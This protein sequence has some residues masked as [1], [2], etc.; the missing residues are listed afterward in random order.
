MGNIVTNV[1]FQPPEPSIMDPQRFFL[2]E[3]TELSSETSQ[4]S[5]TSEKI[6]AFYIDRNSTMTILFSHGN[7]EDIGQIYN[8]FWEFSKKLNVNIMAYDYAGY[9]KSTDKKPKEK[10]CYKGIEAAYKFLI[11]CKNQKP[12]QI[13]LYGRS[14][15]SGPS[16]YLAEKLSS[17]GTPPAGLMLQ[18]PISPCYRVAIPF[19]FT[20]YGDPFPNIDR[21]KRI[22]C[23]VFI[24]HGTRDEIV[25]FK[26]GQDLFLACLEK[27]R[28]KPFWVEGA[29]HNNIENYLK[30]SGLFLTRINIFLNENCRSSVVSHKNSS[31]S[32]AVK[33]S[34]I[35]S[36]IDYN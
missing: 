17:F 27:Y 36:K 9:G 26:H 24:I 19:R 10:K 33:T 5:H 3:T 32:S 25:P 13:I 15:G 4:Q 28:V 14:I 8:W 22:S 7:A 30:D 34:S 23:P 12:N 11:K 18:S 16:C 2:L 20:L 6:S 29:G 21:M 31:K 35:S 1:I